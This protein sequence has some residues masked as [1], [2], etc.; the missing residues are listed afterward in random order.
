M[1]ICNRFKKYT[2]ARRSRKFGND[3]IKSVSSILTFLQKNDKS[4]ISSVT[5]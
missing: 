3:N 4:K 2:K 5:K 1:Y